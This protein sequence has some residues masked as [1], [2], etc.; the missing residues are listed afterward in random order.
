MLNFGEFVVFSKNYSA[1]YFPS[2]RSTIYKMLKLSGASENDTVY[3]LGSGDGRTLE[4]A[5]Q[6]FNVKRAVGIEIDYHWAM[7]SLER[8]KELGLQDRIEIINR[9][10]FECNLR[11]ADVVTLYLDPLS[12]KKL[13]PKL[14]EE[15]KTEARVVSNSFEVEGWKPLKVERIRRYKRRDGPGYSYKKIYLYRMDSI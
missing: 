15:L 14:E 12:N 6:K 9:D 11:P 4:I 10:F 8:I 3:D 7:K 13:K 1:P 5:V 2:G